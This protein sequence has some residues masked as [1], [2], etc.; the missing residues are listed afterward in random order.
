[1]YDGLRQIL[2]DSAAE[3]PDSVAELEARYCQFFQTLFFF[4][5]HK[6]D[7]CRITPY[8]EK[9]PHKGLNPRRFKDEHHICIKGKK[10]FVI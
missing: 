6:N 4:L 2:G 7:L 9:V 5:D 3:L 10:S 1:M 8:T